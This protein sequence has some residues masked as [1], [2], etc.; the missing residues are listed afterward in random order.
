M[1]QHKELTPEEFLE[2]GEDSIF[3]DSNIQTGK[4]DDSF[5]STYTCRATFRNNKICNKT[6][7]SLG[8]FLQHLSERKAH[9]EERGET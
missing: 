1:L 3:T 7:S 4:V 9:Q 6:F 2:Q 8:H 5:D